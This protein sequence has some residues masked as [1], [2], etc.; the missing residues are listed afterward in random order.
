MVD[1]VDVVQGGEEV[2]AVG[3]DGVALGGAEVAGGVVV[4]EDEA[5]GA[6]EQ[7]GAQDGVVGDFDVAE[8]AGGD[9]FVAVDLAVG[10]AGEDD[11]VLLVVVEFGEDDLGDGQDVGDGGGAGVDEERPVAFE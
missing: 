5:A 11:E 4:Q 7:G 2:E 8:A 10:V 1:D 9:D 6:E 3:E